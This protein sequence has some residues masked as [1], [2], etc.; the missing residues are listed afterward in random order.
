MANITFK[1]KI[2]RG[3]RGGGERGRGEKGRR[4]EK[5]EGRKEKEKEKVRNNG[6]ASPNIIVHV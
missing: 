5:G 6:V 3:R 1:M 4:G 2:W